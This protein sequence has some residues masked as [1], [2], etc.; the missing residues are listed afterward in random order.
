MMRALG[1]LAWRVLGWVVVV[2]LV[3]AGVGVGVG[4]FEHDVVLVVL[5]VG[6]F[7]VA[8]VLSWID[9]MEEV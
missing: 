2:A 5:G 4:V 6:F 9:D 1:W 7:V 3:L 8:C